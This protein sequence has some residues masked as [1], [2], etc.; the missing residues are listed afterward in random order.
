MH[1]IQPKISMWTCCQ[2]RN[3]KK[4]KIILLFYIIFFFMNLIFMQFLHCNLLF[5]LIFKRW[6]TGMKPPKL[7]SQAQKN[8]KLCII[9]VT[10]C[11]HSKS[12]A[13]LYEKYFCINFTLMRLLIVLYFLSFLD[14]KN[15]K[16]KSNHW[17]C[18]RR[19]T[20][21]Q[22]THF[23]C[24]ISINICVYALPSFLLKLNSSVYIINVHI[25]NIF[26]LKMINLDICNSFFMCKPQKV[27]VK[28]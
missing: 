1:T 11:Q 20:K 26:I 22:S 7:P 14:S 21:W 5:V 27:M 16:S 15:G 24:D 17:N 10:C 25:F 4:Y 19:Y 23:Y 6:S 3:R 28:K 12:E 18:H 9:I 8:H 13:I 2:Q